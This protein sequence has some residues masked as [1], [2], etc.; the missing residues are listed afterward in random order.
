[1][2]ACA[3]G[4]ES[5]EGPF[6]GTRGAPPYPGPAVAVRTPLGAMSRFDRMRD[7]SDEEDDAESRGGRFR[8]ERERGGEREQLDEFGR[9]I[10]KDRLKTTLGDSRRDERDRDRDRDRERERERERDRDRE[11]ERQRERK[12]QR[13]RE[14][15]KAWAR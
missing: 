10:P 2:F 14:P 4:A 15:Q 5:T 3:S 7:D 13:D 9:V 6:L 11:R 12:R 1:M 8:D